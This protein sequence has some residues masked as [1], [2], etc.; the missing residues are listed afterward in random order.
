MRL[1]DNIINEL[2]NSYCIC[3]ENHKYTKNPEST[4]YVYC[5]DGSRMEFPLIEWADSGLEYLLFAIE[6]NADTLIQCLEWHQY[7]IVT[8]RITSRFYQGT[9]LRVWRTVDGIVILVKNSDFV[10]LISK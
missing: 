2:N 3:G 9:A 4:L 5:Q 6:G 8:G 10:E 7:D 1:L